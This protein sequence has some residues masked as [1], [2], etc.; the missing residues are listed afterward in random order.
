LSQGITIGAPALT[1]TTVRGFAA[2]TAETSLSW[3]EGRLRLNRPAASVSL[4]SE[5]TT[6]AVEAAL[7]ARC[8]PGSTKKPNNA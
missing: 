4:S 7:A 3:A 2:A 5:T 6:T 1:T 8:L